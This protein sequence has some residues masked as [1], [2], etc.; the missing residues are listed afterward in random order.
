MIIKEVSIVRY[1]HGRPERR[2]DRVICENWLSLYL[3]GTLL[4]E[5]PVTNRDIP[6]LVT[7]ILCTEGYL[8][9]KELPQIM[10]EGSICRVSLEGN[11]QV[12]TQ[13]DLVDCAS[14]RVELDENIQPL[15]QGSPR[16]ADDILSLVAEF[17]KIP[18]VY[19]E[20]GG[21]H[22]AAFAQDQIE[23]WADD[24]SR[25]N[26]VDKVIGKGYSGHVD[27]YQGLIITSGRI[28][29]DLILRMVHMGIPMI[30]SISAPTDRALFL[31]E[32]YGV[33]VCGFARGLRMNIYTHEERVDTVSKGH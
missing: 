4:R 20:T 30:V 26:A 6:D 16:T 1:N 2:P 3:N 14:T 5:I 23:Y 28:S 10:L 7:G 19:H 24:I 17:Q 29:S 32:S 8:K 33:T 13:R 27:F 25:R 18:S 22:M 11:I 15:R 9:S 12:K 31:A 21:V